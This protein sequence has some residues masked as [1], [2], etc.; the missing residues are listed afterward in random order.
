M[1]VNGLSGLAD[2]GLLMDPG[3]QWK[4]MLHAPVAAF[5]VGSVSIASRMAFPVLF[6]FVHIVMDQFEDSVVGLFS[7]PEM[8]LLAGSM[9]TLVAMRW[10]EFS[11]GREGASMAEYVRS[12]IKPMRFWN[13]P[14]RS[15]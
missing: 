15:A 5:V 9:V 8:L 7:L 11:W 2:F 14:G 12:E 1:A 4:S 3:G 6:W 13:T 10:R